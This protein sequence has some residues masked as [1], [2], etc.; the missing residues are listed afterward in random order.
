[1]TAGPPVAPLL[2]AAAVLSRPDG[3]VLL[4]RHHAGGP[5]AGPFAGSW[6]LPLTLVA[7]HETAEDAVAR[8]LSDH[9]HLEAG[10]VAFSDTLYLTGRDDARL[11]VNA[12]ECSGW[13]GDPRYEPDHYQDAAW[14]G[15]ADI[16]RRSDLQPQIA[17]WLAERAQDE[18][19]RLTVEALA[20]VLDRSRGS[21]LAAYDGIPPDL[22]ETPGADSLSP[23][24]LLAHI[25]DAETY[26]LAEVERLR[27][28]PGHSWR[29]FNAQQWRDLERYRTPPSGPEARSQ[30]E[31]ARQRTRIWLRSV[32]DQQLAQYGNHMER[33]AVTVGGQ[34]AEIALH[35]Q[36]HAARLVAEFSGLGPAPEG[37]GPS[38]E[39]PGLPVDHLPAAS[40]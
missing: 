20:E 40:G 26:L 27:G 24:G 14:S 35:E 33:G 10:P 32:S 34:L 16:A 9:L 15:T 13:Q 31:S 22:R 18:E 19:P 12:F 1:M 36:E 4:I 25:A 23:A 2:A 29:D 17:A 6:S 8:M 37:A 28:L 5:F 38:V 11:I 7:D 39:P 3:K 21:L 30:L